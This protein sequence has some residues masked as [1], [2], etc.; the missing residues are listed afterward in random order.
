[1]AKERF[2]KTVLVKC[3]RASYE[4]IYEPVERNPTGDPYKE[5]RYSMVALID[6]NDPVVPE[7]QQTI[8]DC[9]EFGRTRYWNNVIPR[10]LRQ[11]LIDGDTPKDDG[12]ERGEEYK[13]HYAISF[14][15]TRKPTVLKK[16]KGKLVKT[17]EPGVIYS[18]CYF[19]VKLGFYA[20]NKGQNGINASPE[21]DTYIFIRDGEPLGG[22]STVSQAELDELAELAEDTDDLPFGDDGA[23]AAPDPFAGFG[24]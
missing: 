21:G 15:S 7:L 18:G 10:N 14:W 6:K 5:P 3:A 17:D 20:Y 11:P 8:K 24:S 4:H 12:T 23:A 22:S 9:A 1:M 16:V 13:G 19:A 2:N